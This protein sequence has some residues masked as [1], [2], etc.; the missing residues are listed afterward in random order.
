M[1]A[2][3]YIG[4]AFTMLSW[5]RGFNFLRATYSYMFIMIFVGLFLWKALGITKMAQ[6][7]DK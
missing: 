6:K 3:N 5:E 1:L 4:T 7:I 2:L